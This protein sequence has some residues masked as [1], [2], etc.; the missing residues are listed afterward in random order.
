MSGRGYTLAQK[1]ATWQIA[2]GRVAYG[3][4]HSPLP[5]FAYGGCN[6]IQRAPDQKRPDR[7]FDQGLPGQG[8]R[9]AI[10]DILAL[11]GK[12]LNHLTGFVAAGLGS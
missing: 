7:K 3:S 10:E 8:D 9:R 5:Y 2:I 12:L 11:H 6:P 1:V 4:A